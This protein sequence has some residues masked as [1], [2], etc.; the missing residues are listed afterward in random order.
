MI[1]DCP[2]DLID[3]ARAGDPAATS[4]LVTRAY[5]HLRRFARKVDGLCPDDTTQEAALAI[6]RRIGQLRDA[7]YL[8]TWAFGIVLNAARLRARRDGRFLFVDAYHD[9][10]EDPAPSP[11]RRA[12]A[13]QL[14][15]VVSTR[16]DGMDA[17]YRAAAELTATER[18]PAEIA[19]AIGVSHTAA[20]SHV[21]RMRVRLRRDPRLRELGA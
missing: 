10:A 8:R 4:D 2:H 16:V 9:V 17:K 13:R 7:A 11:H 19:E 12:V 15:R 14:L 3:A 20:K 6:F 21:H 18:R 5:P 1:L